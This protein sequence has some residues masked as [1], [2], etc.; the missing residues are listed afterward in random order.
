MNETKKPPRRELLE[1]GAPQDVE[2]QLLN[3]IRGVAESNNELVDA[4]NRLRLSYRMLLGGEPASDANEILRQV[5]GAL[6][7]ADKA[8]NLS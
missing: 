1:S 5:E 4:L 7:S 3:W 2:S 8:K 6:R